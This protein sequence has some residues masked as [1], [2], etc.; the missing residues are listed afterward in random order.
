MVWVLVALMLSGLVYT[1]AI[2]GEYRAYVSD[3]LPRI[4]RTE[5][6]A[7]KLGKG[8]DGEAAMR[9]KTR[10]TVQ[11]VKDKIS[12]AKLALTDLDKRMSEL[13]Q[14]EE[15]L[16]MDKYKSDFRKSKKMA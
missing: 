14:K 2:I 4:D 6:R 8:A 13:Q 15:Q 16:E 11:E 7:E 12:E 5:Q 3:I 10:A 9:D 1:V